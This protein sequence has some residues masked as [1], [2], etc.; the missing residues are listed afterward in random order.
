MIL[1]EVGHQVHH[2]DL[3]K[4]CDDAIGSTVHAA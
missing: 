4:R 2:N 1:P 3:C